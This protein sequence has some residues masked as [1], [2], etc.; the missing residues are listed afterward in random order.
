MAAEILAEVVVA[1][2]DVQ[3]ITAVK[4][5]SGAT[6]RDAL[7]RSGIYDRF[8]DEGLRKLPVGIWGK[9]V[10]PDQI[11]SNGD[12]I[13]LYRPLQIDPKEARRRLAD[14]GRTMRQSENK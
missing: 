10:S 13:E 5:S 14:S 8:A 7:E 11:V 12:R 6:V 1:L 4:L 9:L 2:A 3:S